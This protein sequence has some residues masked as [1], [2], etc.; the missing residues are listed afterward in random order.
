LAKNIATKS[1]IAAQAIKASILK[2]YE[3]NLYEGLQ[4]ER[5]TFL[6]IVTDKDAAEGITAFT[7]KRVANFPSNNT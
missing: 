2:S 7:E 6:K 3:L 1:T 5:E 4:Q